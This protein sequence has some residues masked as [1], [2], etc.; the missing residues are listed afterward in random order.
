V[1]RRRSR[2]EAEELG[3]ESGFGNSGQEI[4]D[5]TRKHLFKNPKPSWRSS[6]NGTSRVRPTDLTRNKRPI[7]S[8]KRCRLSLSQEIRLSHHNSPESGIRTKPQ[9][10]RTSN[11]TPTQSQQTS[12]FDQSSTHD[13]VNCPQAAVDSPAAALVQYPET[14]MS[15][16]ENA[17]SDATDWPRSHFN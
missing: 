11:P 3:G 15:S 1:E 5:S 17:G 10:P 9:Q 2:R 6:I 13:P 8:S 16:S 7:F 12:T 14:L 4:R